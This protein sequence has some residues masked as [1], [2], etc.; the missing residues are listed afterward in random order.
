MG[1][2]ALELLGLAVCLLAALG[3]AVL[4]VP[5]G[6]TRQPV[7][8]GAHECAVCH[9]GRAMGDQFSIWM[10]TKHA[11]AFTSLA[12]P[13][14]K[15]IARWSGITMEP[16]ESTVCLGCH[17]TGAEAE[18]WEK[19]PTFF[20][21]EGV[22]CEKCHG[23]GSEYMD[24]NVMTDRDAAVM[25]G[26]NLPT[27]DDCM[28]CHV[29]KGSHRMVLGPRPFDLE[30]AWKRIAH[31]SRGD[32]AKLEPPLPAIGDGGGLRYIGAAGC[33]ECHTGVHTGFQ[34]SKW[35]T[36]KHA[37]AYASLSTPRALEIAAQMKIQGDPRTSVECLKCHATGYQQP[38]G[39]LEDTYSI[40]EGV[41]CEA[42]HGPG[43]QHAVEAGLKDRPSSMA[44]S[45]TKVSAA[46]CDACHT[47]VHGKTFD[48]TAALVAIAHPTITP[49]IRLEPQY[50][51]PLKM[52]LRPDGREVFVVCQTANSV[53][54]VDP[55]TRKKIA[56]IAVGGHPMDVTFAPGGARAFVT[57][58]LD[59]SVSVIDV[60]SRKVIETISVGDEPHGLLTDRSG[61]RLYVLNTAS[62]NISVVD[63]ASLAPVKHLSGS[64]FPWA[65][66]AS[67]D[68]SRIYVT[69]AY[70]RI[71]P[72]RSPS[73]S[74]VTVIETET[75]RVGQRVVV[76]GANLLQG[77]SVHPSGEFALITLLRTKNLV[78][79]TRVHQGWT[80]TNGLGV[81][82]TDGRVDQVLLDQPG[83]CFPDPT[84]VAMTPDGRLALVTSSSTD[85][86]A[87]VD[88]QKLIDMLR[89]ASQYDREH[90]V[91]N[92]LG[93]SAEFVLGHVPTKN[94]PRGLLILPG[95][96]TAYAA[97]ALDD[98]LTVIDIPQRRAVER[99]DLGG[100]R[101][102]TE[103]RYGERLFNSAAI[104]FRRQ[105]SCHSCHPDGHID[106]IT[107]DI[108]PDG[109]GT[110]P[111]DNKTLRGILD[112]APFKWSGKNP[113]FSKQC[114]ARLSTFFT[115]GAPF[116]PEQL[117]AV[118][119]Y[120]CTIP[121][122]PNR[123]RP[124]G[125]PLTDS[126][127]RGKAIFERTRAAG[128]RVI[129][130]ENRC[131]T[132]HFPPLYTDRRLHD[133]GTKAPSDTT[134]LIDTPH[135]TN[136]YN[137]APYLHNG[138]AGTLEEIWTRHNPD[139]KHG[140]T[141]DMTKDQLN[142]LVEYLKTL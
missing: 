76:P 27:K 89:Q 16:Q 1:R 46:T 29:E 138:M 44:A 45:L 28:N 119:L 69:N 11:T 25:A 96:K 104:T 82:W 13:E 84:D 134:G 20:I 5:P 115:R 12:K 40:H 9:D 136:I 140:V 23:P 125:A 132:C 43:S 97:N 61:K 93:K 117:A 6:R 38:A 100:P 49:E 101:E 47:G 126:Q 22:Q 113:S 19:D 129:P 122:P 8:V 116:T 2:R 72:L 15:L 130:K 70:S 39:G 139:D 77:V 103:V 59:D 105:F 62:D 109:I 56:E 81:V 78:P 127:R 88:V 79:M 17:A 95:G 24:A 141:N 102:I 42:C 98:S 34:F 99:I 80:I 21:K 83:M 41:S 53:I 35:R 51:T 123:Y 73:I 86:V 92:H 111:V 131:T 32:F 64:R 26:L 63:T 31:P 75:G 54:V 4:A 120:V 7:Y 133:V 90:I 142:D 3:Q 52:A 50:K 60:A 85:R 110:D 112:T 36:S 124:L 33:A 57:N 18:P 37:Y 14:A 58:R 65:L 128:G 121:R 114:G 91:P 107:Y 106:A 135:L 118:D 87:V 71:V 30:E 108:E 66:A 10:H 68:G 55:S 137:S 48:F 67:A 74:E 94:S